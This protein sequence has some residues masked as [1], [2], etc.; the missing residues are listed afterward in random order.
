[1]NRTRMMREISRAA[2]RCGV[3]FNPVPEHKRG[4]HDFWVCGGFKFAIPRHREIASGTAEQILK[5]LEPVLG[6]DWWRKR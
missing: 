2:K 3:D 5:D 4:K 6:K 1:M